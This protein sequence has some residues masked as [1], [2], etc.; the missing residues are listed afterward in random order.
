MPEPPPLRVGSADRQPGARPT[1][2]GQSPRRP[3]PRRSRGRW[4][5]LFVLAALWGL[6]IGG[7]ILG[8]F[9]LS[10]PD[11][12]QLA[13]AERRPDLTILADDGSVIATFGDLFGRPLTLQQM[14]RYLPEAVIATEDRRF[15]SN[16]GID[17]IGMLRAA[18][19]DLRAGRIVE[20]GSTITQQLAKI[21][22]LTPE[23]SISRKIRETLLAL[24]LDHR[25]AKNQILEIYL[26]RVYLGAGAYGVD[27]A[28]HRYFGKSAADLDLYECAVIA[29]L[30]K[31]PSRFSPARDRAAAA[32]RAAQVLHNM[33][34]AGFINH[35]QAQDAETHGAEWAAAG[36]EGSRYFADWV[37]D[38]V[39]DFADATDRDLIV[40]T[41]LDP[42]LQRLAE[43]SA[44][45]ILARYG[46]R[47]RVSQD[48]FVALAP[49][50]AVRAMVGGRDYAE[51]QFNRATEAERQPG[52]AFKPFVYL[53]GLEAGL[54]PDDRFDDAP[55][56][57]GNWQ[58]HDYERHY[59]GEMSLSQALAQ[60]INTIA[61]RVAERAGIAQVI[62][63]ANRLGIASTLPRDASITLG[64]ADVNLLELTAAYAPFANGGNGVIPYG[65]AEIR[66]RRGNVVYRREGSGPG[67]VVAPQYVGMMN[68]MLQGV[69]ADG[70]GRLAALPRP[71]AGKTGTT[72]DYRDA[73]FIGYTADLVAGVWFGND[74]DSPMRRVTGGSLPAAAWRKFMLAATSGMPVRP[75]PDTGPPRAP[76]SAVAADES[77]FARLLGWLVGAPAQPAAPLRFPDPPS[78]N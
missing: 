74:D 50:G 22:F 32:A 57:I 49:D 71:A 35:A 78:Q 41:T 70:T 55:I 15:Y 39:H 13:V 20:G 28:A 27:A 45:G 66:D 48:A 65:I 31:A 61:V 58:P 77:P 42:R 8:Y 43:A 17:P 53:A 6:I 10:L 7:G 1:R 52:S 12:S 5:K 67:P 59:Q 36:H 11:T 24:W 62:A 4:L 34:E 73:W 63:T 23:R 14:P 16:F 68:E 47:D 64:T 2:P 72:Q 29:G 38:Q 44:G 56:R 18:V 46:G 51:S 76:A 37:A 30:L 60:S 54:R 33:V 25:F 40:E 3:A 21:L 26:N 19:A 69:I 9:A 75:L